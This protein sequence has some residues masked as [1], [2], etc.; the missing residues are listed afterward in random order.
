MLRSR[1]RRAF[2][3]LEVMLAVGVLGLVG[4]GIYRFVEA[5]LTSVRVSTEAFRE[6]EELASLGRFLRMQLQDLPVRLGAIT[7]E[8]HQFEG[9]PADELRWI[10]A[11][12][13]GLF[14]RFGRG[15][16][17]VTLTTQRNE[18]GALELGL[19]RQELEAR[20]AA[21][22]LPLLSNVRGLEVRY[23]DPRSQEWME[24][25]T[26]LAIRPALVRLRLWHGE[27]PEAHEWVLGI[28]YASA[29]AQIPN[30]N[31]N[32]GRRNRSRPTP[33]PASPGDRPPP[34]PPGP[35]R[36]GSPPPT[37]R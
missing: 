31:F 2:T 13:S 30:L 26:D 10:A 17:N 18:K 37:A 19:R 4:L 9:I 3:L 21:V 8:P 6:R 32:R 22:W 29:T 11:P 28:P 16:Y 36:P 20:E 35:E 23:Y 25:W 14:T 33:P 7:G 5:M 27:D 15:E 1:Y 24:K 34:Q 12:G